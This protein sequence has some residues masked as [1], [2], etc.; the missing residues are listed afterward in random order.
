MPHKQFCLLTFNEP[1]EFHIHLI[2]ER[3]SEYAR[4]PESYTSGRVATGRVSF[5]GQVKG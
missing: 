2:V 5:A 4:D 1:Y 3:G